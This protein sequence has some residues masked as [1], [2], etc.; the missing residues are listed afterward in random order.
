MKTRRWIGGKK[1]KL[2]ETYLVGKS[3]FLYVVDG[4]YRATYS[5]TVH[6]LDPEM[7]SH[8]FVDPQVENGGLPLPKKPPPSRYKA[9]YFELQ[10][11]ETKAG[12]D[13][14][15]KKPVLYS[16]PVKGI[17]FELVRLPK[18]VGES[19]PEEIIDLTAATRKK[20]KLEETQIE[21]KN[22]RKEMLRS[23]SGR[24]VSIEFPSTPFGP[25]TFHVT[26]T[27]ENIMF[28]NERDHNC[29]VINMEPS[30]HIELEYYYYN[31]PM[32]EC[33]HVP[34][35]LFF[36]FL[37]QLGILFKMNISLTDVSTKSIPKSDCVVKAAVFAIA[38][39][40]TFYQRF[41]FVNENFDEFVRYIQRMSFHEFLVVGRV[42]LGRPEYSNILRWL[43]ENQLDEDT[44][45]KVVCKT[46]VEECKNNEKKNETKS[47][48]FVAW[49]ATFIAGTERTMNLKR[50]TPI[51]YTSNWLLK[52]R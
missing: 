16:K 18:L 44:T 9:P 23:G 40:Q 3:Y 51:D 30:S 10:N 49:F 21:F 14:K 22:I 45:M 38:G 4:V 29:I 39:Y 8:I 12:E 20:R 41:G 42:E 11:Y 6:T 52:L 5:R 25:Y 13:V 46:V 43:R 37:T 15:I 33:P 50:Y 34:H 19:S 26:L 27:R 47:T 48:E 24:K 7:Y 36:Y 1:M 35:N 2:P 17:A 28:K 32:N 31:V